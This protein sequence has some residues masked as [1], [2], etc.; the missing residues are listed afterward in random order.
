MRR[1]SGFASG[2]ALQPEPVQREVQ[3]TMLRCSRQRDGALQVVVLA[4]GSA[5][6]GCWE[7][8]VAPRCHV[9]PP[10]LRSCF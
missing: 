8:P 9:S 4:P 10:R 3:K 7:G 6:A 5:A 1:G 2:I